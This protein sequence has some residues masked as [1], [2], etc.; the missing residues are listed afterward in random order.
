[1][2]SKRPTTHPNDILARHTPRVRELVRRLR[3]LVIATVPDAREVAY[4]VWK[5]LGY[6]HP[7][8]GYFCAIFPHSD[9]V[10]LGFEYGV[11]LNDPDG[12]LEGTGKQLRYVVINEGQAI[13]GGAIKRLLENAVDLPHQRGVKLGQIKNLKDSP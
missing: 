1:M 5:G 8:G 13:P 9:E 4:P 12:V 10:K 7:E 6:H 2:T 11:L 3:G